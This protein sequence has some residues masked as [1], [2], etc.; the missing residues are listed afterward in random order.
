MIPSCL[1]AGWS[2]PSN[3]RRSI[4]ADSWRRAAENCLLKVRKGREEGKEQ[5]HKIGEHL[6]VVLEAP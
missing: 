6:T 4:V 2:G 5:K 1:V 3:Y